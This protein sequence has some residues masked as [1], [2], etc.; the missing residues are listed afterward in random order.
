MTLPSFKL[1]SHRGEKLPRRPYPWHPSARDPAG[2]DPTTRAEIVDVV[3]SGGYAP[4]W[5]Y[6]CPSCRL[7]WATRAAACFRAS[8]L[9]GKKIVCSACD[10]TPT[11]T[12]GVEPTEIEE[13]EIRT[14]T[15][16]LRV[17][18]EYWIGSEYHCDYE[19][20]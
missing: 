14:R 19:E 2:V 7:E 16:A 11:P 6:R 5:L 8:G 4:G 12:S 15:R 18:V 20:R 13:P 1:R 10:P 9:G 3:R 17:K